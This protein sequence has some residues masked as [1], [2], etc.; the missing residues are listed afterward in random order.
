VTASYL[1]VQ[2][3][4]IQGGHF[5]VVGLV[6]DV[7]VLHQAVA[8]LPPFGHG[9][10]GLPLIGGAVVNFSLSRRGVA[11]DDGGQAAVEVIDVVALG[12]HGAPVRALQGRRSSCQTSTPE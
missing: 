12:Q 4:R 3:V 9:K 11:N 7:A 1:H 6:H 5:L 2:N 10:V 8:R